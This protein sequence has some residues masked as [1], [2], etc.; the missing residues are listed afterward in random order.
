MRRD[1]DD[2]NLYD[3]ALE[4]NLKKIPIRSKLKGTNHKLVKGA[5][6]HVKHSYL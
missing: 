4:A 2:K 1:K 3:E 5:F 6:D